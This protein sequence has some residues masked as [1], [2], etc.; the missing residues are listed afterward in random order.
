[1]SGHLRLET[2]NSSSTYIGYWSSHCL[3]F[4]AS[5]FGGK[6]KVGCIKQREWERQVLILCHSAIQFGICAIFLRRCSSVTIIPQKTIY[7]EHCPRLCKEILR[8]RF[9][10]NTPQ[11]QNDLMICVNKEL[12][13]HSLPY[14]P[15]DRPPTPHK[16]CACVVW[17][18]SAMTGPRIGRVQ[19][20]V[21]LDWSPSSFRA[22]PSGCSDIWLEL[23]H[24]WL[25]LLLSF[26]IRAV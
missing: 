1:M 13:A 23:H 10:V 18:A 16:N 21:V 24:P 22:G 12:Y 4:K 19:T 20:T 25:I 26:Q 5:I 7:V 9:A 6:I 15:R 2:S 17:S 3:T 8:T 11:T 14:I